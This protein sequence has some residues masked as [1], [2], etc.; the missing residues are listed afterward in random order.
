MKNFLLN[1]AQLGKINDKTKNKYNF[2]E[3]NQI[4]AATNLLYMLCHTNNLL[5]HTNVLKT[6][7]GAHVNVNVNDVVIHICHSHT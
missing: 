7:I 3:E 5:C 4:S 1:N 6:Y 2:N